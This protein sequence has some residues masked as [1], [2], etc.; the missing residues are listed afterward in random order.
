MEVTIGC[1]IDSVNQYKLPELSLLP[2]SE[3]GEYVSHL[4]WWLTSCCLFYIML[5]LISCFHACAH[6]GS[7]LKLIFSNH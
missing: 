4:S 3:P 2:R 1:G 6:M 7:V 5:A